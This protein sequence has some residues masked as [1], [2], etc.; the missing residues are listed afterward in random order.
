MATAIQ[1]VCGYVGPSIQQGTRTVCPICHAE[2]GKAA[3]PL[4]STAID[5]SLRGDDTR[6][7][8]SLN[9]GSV[10]ARPHYRIPC[11]NGHVNKTPARMLNTQATCPK[12]HASY[13]IDIQDSL[14]YREEVARRQ[15][16]I[17]EKFARKWLRRAIVAAVLVLLSFAGMIGYSLYNVRRGRR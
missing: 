10:G 3:G 1:C 12:C 5:D 4:P 13:V 2:P 16:E 15:A 7:D 6:R 8:R 9:D 17:D 11:P 14:E